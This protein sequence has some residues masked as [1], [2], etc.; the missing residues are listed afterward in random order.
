MRLATR[1]SVVLRSVERWLWFY[2]PIGDRASRRFYKHFL[3]ASTALLRER[4]G[5]QALSSA[6]IAFFLFGQDYKN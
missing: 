2:A 6:F 3:A 5:K 4:E 1:S